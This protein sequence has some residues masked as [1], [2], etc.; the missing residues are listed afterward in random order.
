MRTLIQ[1]VCI[2]RLEELDGTVKPFAHDRTALRPERLEQGDRI[3]LCLLTRCRCKAL[4]LRRF[5]ARP[6]QHEPRSGRHLSAAI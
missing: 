4:N 3:S 1:L 5:S 2:F 6:N